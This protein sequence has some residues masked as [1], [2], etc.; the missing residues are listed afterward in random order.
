[1]EILKDITIL[2]VEDDQMLQ[3]GISGIFKKLFKNVITAS[4]G[5]EGL[6]QFKKN[7]QG[8]EKIDI[9]LSD[10]NMPKMNGIE[11]IE[12][13][14][15]IDEN[16][17][18]VFLT[19]FSDNDYLLKALQLNVSDYLIKPF[20]VPDLL[21]K[22]EKAYLPVHQK[23]ILLEQ[24]KQLELLNEQIK[25]SSEQTIN[26][27]T[28][29]IFK[30][31]E[32]YNLFNQYTITSETDLNGVITYVSRPFLDI[33]GFEEDELIGSTHQKVRHKDTEDELFKSLWETITKGEVWRGEMKNSTKS[34]GYYWVDGIVFPLFD[35]DNNIRGYKSIRVNISDQK[36]R[37][38][39]VGDLI[40]YDDIDLD[41]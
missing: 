26:K 40:S 30:A 24:K 20:I 16:I 8:D 18:V 35:D 32:I 2:F 15:K 3:E 22:I 27:L 6:E 31:K 23:S 7:M 36:L 38:E 5:S 33:S 19:A 34:G 28:N 17:P 37:D 39:L 13:I 25:R 10:I 29:D 9:I 21:K 11:M 41:F 4:D 1:M 12:E 14:K